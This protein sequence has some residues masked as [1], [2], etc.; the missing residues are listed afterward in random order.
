[1][2]RGDIAP[3]GD[4]VSWKLEKDF[5]KNFKDAG[6][7]NIRRLG[8]FS[9]I[10]ANHEGA[11]AVPTLDYQAIS[12]KEAVGKKLQ[13]FDKNSIAVSTTGELRLD[14]RRKV[15]AAASPKSESVVVTRGTA[16]KAKLLEVVNPSV[17]QS[18][19][20]IALDGKTLAESNS[21]IILQ[22]T[23]AIATGT[24]FTDE[25]LSTMTHYG[26]S[27]LL[28]RRGS[29]QIRLAV[30]RNYQVKALNMQGDTLG[31][32]PGELRAN[33]FMFTADNSRFKGGIVAYH[34][35]PENKK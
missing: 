8:L 3:A 33:T 20:A 6:Y 28:L 34:L 1:M 25:D 26:K 27:P 22:L 31:V 16:L 2:I 5:W 29:C 18:V 24:R 30:N 21:I 4:A 19:T 9:K 35:V 32:I 14:T 13:E 10:G 23:D 12:P 7:P 15:F 11:T 17:F